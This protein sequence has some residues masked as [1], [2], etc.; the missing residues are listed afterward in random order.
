V[1]QLS[2]V[3]RPSALVAPVR[4]LGQLKLGTGPFFMTALLLGLGFYIIFPI[5]ILLVMSFNVAPDIFVGPARWGLDNWTRAWEHRIVLESLWNSFLIWFLVAVVAFPISIGIALILART[6]IPF[7]HGLEYM[8]WIAVMFPSLASTIGW[9]M[10]LDPDTG[11]LNHAAK[12]LPFVSQ[13]PFNIYSVPGIVW[14]K[15]MGDGIAFKVMLLTPAFRNMDAALEEAA[16]VS[17]TSKLGSMLRV[18]LPMMISPIVLILCLQLI[19]VFQG[20]ETEQLLGPRWGFYVYS[21]LIYRLAHNQPPQ[22]GEAVV[23]A[24]ITFLIIAAIIPFQGWVTRRRQYTT[25]S[26][27]YRP[28]LID[29]G[30]WKWVVFGAIVGL[31]ALLTIVPT[32]VVIVGSFMS[33]VGFFEANPLWTLKHWQFVFTDAGILKAAGTTLALA[34]TA[35]ICSP[36]LFSLLAYVIVRTRYRGRGVLDSIIWGSSAIPGILSGLGLLIMFLL[37]PG[38][39]WLYGSIW[40]LILVV[41]VAGKTTGVNVMKGVFVQLGKDMEESSRV[42]GAGWFGTYFRVVLPILMPTMVLI[43]VLSFVGAAGAT[44]SIILLA[45]RDTY[46]L[47]LLVLQLA[48]PT[49]G[50]RE[51][52]G[53]IS[54]IIMV[55]TLAIAWVARAYGFRVGV[56]QT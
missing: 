16:R 23:L 5:V 48:D 22:Y 21:T 28:G 30:R 4:A 33:R 40:A 13:A 17:G 20:F 34:L 24:S 46:T 56:R 55:M 52:A 12:L 54:L 26:S 3:R 31:L 19:R 37:V 29:L 9:I 51:A 1:A 43:G 8:F 27:G 42:A 7:A 14:A 45:S 41:I 25:I 47:S 53:I 2:D 39:N 50:R 35:G 18:T 36:I 49:V 6:R 44:S 38:L 11:M 10:L 15:L 32:I